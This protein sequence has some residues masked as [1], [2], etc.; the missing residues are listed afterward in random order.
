MRRG[1]RA[2]HR[3]IWLVLAFLLPA[4]MIVS[5]ALRRVGPLESPAVQL[6]PPQ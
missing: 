3:R 2:V 5:M 1:H 4:V 6:S